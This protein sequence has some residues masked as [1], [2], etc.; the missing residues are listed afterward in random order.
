MVDILV[1]STGQ[2]RERIQLDIDRDYIV[3]DEEAV[4]YGLVDEV[5][6]KRRLPGR[7]EAIRA[8]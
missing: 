3:R 5:L 7:Q 1:A 8:S 6:R 4:A 2:T